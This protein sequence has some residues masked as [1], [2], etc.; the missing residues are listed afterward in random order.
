MYRKKRENKKTY[1]LSKLE[2]T[3]KVDCLS[4]KK[5]MRKENEVLNIMPTSQEGCGSLNKLKL[6]L[7]M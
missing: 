4:G 7:N 3:I 6:S 1:I 2:G 5:L